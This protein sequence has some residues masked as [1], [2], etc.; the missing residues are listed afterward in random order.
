VTSD[1]ISGILAVLIGW[2]G[3]AQT[4]PGVQYRIDASA[5][6]IELSVY[7]EGI[8]KIFGHN[9]LIAAKKFSGSVYFEAGRVTDSTV[10]LSIDARSLTVLDPDASEKDRHDV[11]ETMAG[12]QVLDVARHEKITFR[13]TGVSLVKRTG[14]DWA[15]TLDGM[16]NLHGVEKPVTLPVRIRIENNRLHAEGETTVLQ[17]D[18]GM[19]PVKVGGGAVKVKDQVKISFNIV[20]ERTD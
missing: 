2:A 10:A 5:S 12:L 6:R 15:I 17:T 8:L 11:Q 13:S 18:F 20:A 19:T 9:H 16:L 1:L 4:G 14:D 3:P 7:K